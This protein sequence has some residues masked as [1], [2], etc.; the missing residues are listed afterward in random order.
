MPNPADRAIVER[1]ALRIVELFGPT[2]QP[3]RIHIPD[4]DPYVAVI[5]GR[6]RTMA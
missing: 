3:R 4:S 6:L 1:A 5:V 2:Y